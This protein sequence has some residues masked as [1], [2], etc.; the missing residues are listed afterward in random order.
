[1]LKTGGSSFEGFPRTKLTTLPEAT[2]MWRVCRLWVWYAANPPLFLCF[3]DADRTLC[4]AITTKWTY[5]NPKSQMNFDAIYNSE[6]DA[7]PPT[8]ELVLFG[9]KLFAV[10]RLCRGA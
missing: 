6:F 8:T 1:V 7:A 3:D 4:T 10:C 5:T 9:A 2:G